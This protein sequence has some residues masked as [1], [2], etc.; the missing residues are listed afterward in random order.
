V[1][2]QRLNIDA[3]PGPDAADTTECH[4][5]RCQGERMEERQA[6]RDVT[7]ARVAAERVAVAPP[8][9]R[10]LEF[11]QYI[12]LE[13][14]MTLGE[15]MAIAGT[16]DLASRDKLSERLTYMPTTADPFVTTITLVGGRV[17]DLERTRKF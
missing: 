9:V 17:S 1:K 11:R 7:D 4:T 13:R 10:G 15:V 6:R 14:G 3:K 2:A 12:R 8:P 5:V 16:P